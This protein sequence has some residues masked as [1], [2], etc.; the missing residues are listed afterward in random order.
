MCINFS[1]SKYFFVT[2]TAIGSL[3]ILGCF[4][5]VVILEEDKRIQELNKVLM[6][7]VCPGESIDQS[8]NELSSQMR[9]IVE[10]KVREGWTDKQIKDYF[11]QRYGPRVVMNPPFSGFSIIAWII[12]PFI[13]VSSAI[14][15][16]FY[17]R[18]KLRVE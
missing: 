2:I 4:S 1:F 16:V 8:Q 17:I 6:C 14:L 10:E 11:V 5:S 18:S 13:L 3:V 9:A 12:P 7:P 15:F